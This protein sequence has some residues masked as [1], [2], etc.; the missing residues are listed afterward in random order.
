MLST[1]YALV[2]TFNK[3]FANKSILVAKRIKINRDRNSSGERN[4][5]S[6]SSSKTIEKIIWNNK[7]KWI[8]FNHRKL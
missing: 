1:T 7:Y 3:Y 2:K 5:Y 6:L 4:F 8:P